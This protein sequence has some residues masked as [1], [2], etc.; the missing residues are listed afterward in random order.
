MSITHQ[1][2]ISEDIILKSFQENHGFDT[3]EMD[4]KTLKA[5]IRYAKS[6]GYND[7][8][9]DRKSTSTFSHQS[10][11]SFKIAAKMKLMSLLNA[12]HDDL[13]NIHLAG[14]KSDRQ[15]LSSVFTGGFFQGLWKFMHELDAM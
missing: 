13:L 8:Y 5:L 1:Q 7:G 15:E 10:V 14:K 3:T 9:N 11:T 6:I 4:E 2:D 12:N